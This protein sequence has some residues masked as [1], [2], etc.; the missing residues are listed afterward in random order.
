MEKQLELL[1]FSVRVV[2]RRWMKYASHK[3]FR[4]LSVCIR[5]TYIVFLLYFLTRTCGNIKGWQFEEMILCHAFASVSYGILVLFFTG[6]RDFRVSKNRMDV[7]FLKPT[8]VLQQILIEKI[9]WF[10]CAGHL[11]LGIV[12][13]VVGITGCQLKLTWV[14]VL[15]LFLNLA[16]GVLIR[17][18]IWLFCCAI[19]CMF[20]DKFRLRTLLQYILGDFLRFPLCWFPAAFQK[21][22]TFVIPWGFVTFYPVLQLLGRSEGTPELF[23]YLALPI[24][25]IMYLVS[26][27]LWRLGLQI[28][29]SPR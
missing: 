7:Y 6:L 9:D 19:E 15:F 28:Y 27:L 13:F 8:G 22:V 24:G 21:L 29:K 10:A 26:Y 5:E 20:K 23:Q 1:T 3:M 11:L 16:G 12:L 4:A 25:I 14:N 17:A 18:S 2:W